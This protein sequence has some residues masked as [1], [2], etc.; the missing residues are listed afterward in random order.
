MRDVRTETRHKLHRQKSRYLNRF[1]TTSRK[2]CCTELTGKTLDYV[3]V[4]SLI[5]PTV[6]DRCFK[7][8]NYTQKIPITAA[9]TLLIACLFS[10][11]ST[12]AHYE[13]ER[14]VPKCSVYKRPYRQDN[15]TCFSTASTWD[16]LSDPRVSLMRGS[17][18]IILTLQ[19]LN[20]CFKI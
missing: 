5:D 19:Y 15:L 6:W 18:G 9:I 3:N 16:P 7:C 17:Q 1:L 14:I 4:T 10:R 12:Q 20:W 13:I 2:P 8:Q 11:T